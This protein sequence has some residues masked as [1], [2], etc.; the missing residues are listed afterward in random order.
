M[1][2]IKTRFNDFLNEETN[3]IKGIYYS[4]SLDDETF[5]GT[6]FDSNDYGVFFTG[7]EKLGNE[8]HCYFYGSKDE[9]EKEVE[10]R[11]LHL[12]ENGYLFES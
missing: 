12:K 7:S 4:D 1:K 9:V 10:K 5:D 6:T 11:N 2:N 8:G 3:N